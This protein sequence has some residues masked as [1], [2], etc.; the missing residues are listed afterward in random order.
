LIELLDGEPQKEIVRLYMNRELTSATEALSTTF[1]LDEKLARLAIK[2]NKFEAIKD[3]PD[4]SWESKS[5]Y[6]LNMFEIA[7]FQIASMRAEGDAFGYVNGK[8]VKGAI[9]ELIEIAKVLAVILGIEIGF[10]NGKFLDN[11]VFNYFES[12]RGWRVVQFGE[13]FMSPI[14]IRTNKNGTKEEV[15][16]NV[17]LKRALFAWYFYNTPS[18][19]KRKT[20]PKYFEFE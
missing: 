5:M 15:Q 6:K 9:F 17:E 12:Y 1:L 2:L 20:Q 7:S 11:L 14:I 18:P 3:D 4:I 16:F 13:N 10:S 8:K 19:E